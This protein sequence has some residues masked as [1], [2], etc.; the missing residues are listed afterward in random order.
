MKNII[1]KAGLLV[2]ALFATQHIFPLVQEDRDVVIRKL[3]NEL[4]PR[5][6]DGKW[7]ELEASRNV[8]GNYDYIRI[9]MPTMNTPGMPHTKR[10]LGRF[11]VPPYTADDDIDSYT[12]R[13]KQHLI[14]AINMINETLI[15]QTLPS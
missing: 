4:R 1:Q 6:Y 8:D 13:F 15:S 2:V 10:H 11:E 5:L 9:Y 14:K 12:A 7:V 3:T